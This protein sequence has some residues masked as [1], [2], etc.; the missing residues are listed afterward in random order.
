MKKIFFFVLVITALFGFSDAALAGDMIYSATA[1]GELSLYISPTEESH[2]V[3]TVPACVEMELLEEDKTWG[4]VKVNNKCGWVNLS[5]TRKT[6]NDAAE[7]TGGDIKKSVKVD[8]AGGKASL[9]NLPS[10]DRVAG[11]EVL[12][13]IPNETVLKII[14]ET[15]SGWGLVSMNGEYAW[16]K[17]KD[18]SAFKENID[19]DKYGIFYVYVL[20][21]RG[22][23][24]SLWSDTGRSRRLTVIPDCVRLTVQEKS[25]NYGYVAYN[26]INGWIDLTETAQSLLN[27]QMGAGKEVNEEYTLITPEG[28]NSVQLITVPSQN[29]WDGAAAVAT[30]KSET[31]VFVLRTTMSGWGLIYYEGKLGW[32]PPEMLFPATKEEA[33]FTEILKTP[34]KGYVFT[35][36]SKGMTLFAEADG[37]T[38]IVTVP[39]CVEILIIAE[40]DGYEFISCDYGCGWAKKGEYKE[41]F[42]DA[43]HGKEDTRKVGYILKDDTPIMGL[44]TLEER[45]HSKVLGVAEKGTVFECIRTVT[46]DKDRWALAEIN[47]QTGW[48]RLG[49]ARKVSSLYLGALGVLVGIILVCTAAFAVIRLKKKKEEG[50]QENESGKG[51]YYADSGAHEETPDVPHQ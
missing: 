8:A 43:L 48:I 35:E 9:Y 36:K 3:A 44:P 19:T 10:E 46:S 7:S 50:E 32:A 1:E 14:R 27:S 51:L 42:E 23:G 5:F 41:T 13:R 39:E 37:K 12:Y 20:S 33:P 25:G 47:G 15:A 34:V 26:G 18:T 6:Y 17:T 24:I 28:E 11:S 31:T 29:S 45:C 4:L 21:E 2:I 16:V 38:K 49:D 22:R 30:V 40:K